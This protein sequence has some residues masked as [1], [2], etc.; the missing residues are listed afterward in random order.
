VKRIVPRT[1]TYRI[2]VP[3]KMIGTRAHR[4]TGHVEPGPWNFR[5]QI[6]RISDES[7][8]ESHTTTL[9]ERNTLRYL[10]TSLVFESYCVGPRGIVIARRGKTIVSLPNSYHTFNFLV[11]LSR[12]PHSD[13]FS[14]SPSDG[15]SFSVLTFRRLLLF[16]SSARQVFLGD[17]RPHKAPLCMYIRPT[18]WLRAFSH[19]TWG[20]S[21]E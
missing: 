15:F 11:G 9:D 16:R 1:S 6:N 20:R 10:L 7:K 5:L 14:F 3:I 4:R 13:G 19:S 17:S 2:T 8:V 21:V 12:T 18:L